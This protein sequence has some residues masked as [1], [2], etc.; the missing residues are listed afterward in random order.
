MNMASIINRV[1][2][3]GGIPQESAELNQVYANVLNMPVLVPERPIT[4]LGSSLFAFLAAGTFATLEEAQQALC[5]PFRVYETATECSRDLPAFVRDVSR[6]CISPWGIHSQTPVCKLDT[7]CL[8]S[9]TISLRVPR[10][11]MNNARDAMLLAC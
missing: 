7:F 11:R 2:H 5:V 4:S 3:G 6:L 10:G 8:N 9:R 1:I